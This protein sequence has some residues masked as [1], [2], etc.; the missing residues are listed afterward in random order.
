MKAHPVSS[1]DNPAFKAL[2]ASLKASGE[3]RTHTLILGPKLIEAWWETRASSAGARF[4]PEGWVKLE[5]AVDHKLEAALRLPTLVL[6]E[7][8]MRELTDMG[9]VPTLALHVSLGPEP[10]T[11]VGPR[12]L[13]AW[14]VQDPG[15]LGALLRAA[16]AFGFTDALLGPGCADPFAPKALR[17][18]MGAAFVLPIR[19]RDR[20]QVD[21]GQ[22]WALEGGPGAIP[23]PEADLREPLQVWVGNEGH[24]WQGVELPPGV[25]QLAIPIQG[26]ES[27]NASVAAGIACYEVAR[28]LG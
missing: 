21:G 2:R 3:G 26:V 11:P 12:A 1:K 20:L 25:S 19:R 13:G 28:R 15:N 17:G 23:L 18:A 9:S 7:P 24:G 8:R 10:E 16:V 27:L 14:G 6:P 5:D 4:R 22:V